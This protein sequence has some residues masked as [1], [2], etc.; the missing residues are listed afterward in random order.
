MNHKSKQNYLKCPSTTETSIPPLTYDELPNLIMPP[1]R[2]GEATEVDENT[3]IPAGFTYLGQ[4]IAHD[5]S[6]TRLYDPSETPKLRLKSLYGAGP[7]LMPYLY[8]HYPKDLKKTNSLAPPSNVAKGKRKHFYRGIK[9][10]LRKK[11]VENHVY[12]DVDR[13]KQGMPLM[14]DSRNDQ[15]LILSQLH[16]AFIRFHNAVV[17]YFAHTDPSLTGI[18]LLHLTRSTIVQHYQWMIVHFY[19]KGV[20]HK[21][22]SVLVEKLIESNDNFIF[23][24]ADLP[25]VLTLEFSDAVLRMGHSQIA[26]EYTLSGNNNFQLF[27]ENR[28]DL[29]GFIDRF[30]KGRTPIMLDWNKFFNLGKKRGPQASSSIDHIFVHTL[31][32]IPFYAPGHK[33]LIQNDFFKAYRNTA[34]GDY[35]ARCLKDAKPEYAPLTIDKLRVLQEFDKF[36]AEV[37]TDEY[38]QRMPLWLYILVEAK[39]INAGNCLGPL[40]SQIMAEQIIWILKHDPESFIHVPGFK[41]NEVFFEWRAFVTQPP[42]FTPPSIFGIHDII[43]FP[44]Y[45]GE[46]INNTLSTQ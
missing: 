23:F 26:Q 43:K 13:N 2:Q 40:G 16:V 20:L 18:H 30:K 31:K 19:L 27:N 39:V 4:M 10:R 12:Y 41:P 44:D 1:Q 34:T 22:S 37:L 45:V 14:A 5:I 25:P 6:F 29:R 21:D 46:I 32:N 42:T 9:L 8:V 17:D 15:H 3:E 35:Y 11:E 33:N 36:P 28:N 38:L 24:A 7:V